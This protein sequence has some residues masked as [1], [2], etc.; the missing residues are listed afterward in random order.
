MEMIFTQTLSVRKSFNEW[1]PMKNSSMIGRKNALMPEAAEV[2]KNTSYESSYLEGN[3]KT[4]RMIFFFL[5][6]WISLQIH[7]WLQF[8]WYDFVQGLICNM[9]K[10]ILDNLRVYDNRGVRI[11]GFDVQ[12]FPWINTIILKILKKFTPRSVRNIK[13]SNPA[14]LDHW[15]KAPFFIIL[16][17]IRVS[18]T[19]LV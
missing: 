5:P 17:I 6:N 16:L 8:W 10:L 12:K 3:M 14:K 1:N 4:N 9:H 19:V 15:T 18:H 2:K 7:K 13:Y 11:H